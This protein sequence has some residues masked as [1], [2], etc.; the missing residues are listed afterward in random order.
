MC[1]LVNKAWSGYVARIETIA[2]K[3]YVILE[4]YAVADSEGYQELP[5]PLNW[6][7]QEP[8]IGEAVTYTH[9]IESEG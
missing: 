3:Q 2:G 7:E 1:R 5:V 4:L 6:F 9:S 8:T